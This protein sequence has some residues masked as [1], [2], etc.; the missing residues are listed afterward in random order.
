MRPGYQGARQFVS[1]AI[2]GGSG[3]RETPRLLAKWVAG[4]PFPCRARVSVVPAGETR[5]MRP[6]R[7]LLQILALSGDAAVAEQAPGEDGG[8]LAKTGFRREVRF[9]DGRCGHGIGVPNPR[10][11]HRRGVAPMDTYPE[12]RKSVH[13]P[14][15]TSSDDVR[16]RALGWN[17]SWIRFNSS[18][19]S[20]RPC[21]RRLRRG[22]QVGS[23]ST[24]AGAAAAES[25][26]RGWAS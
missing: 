5:R 24:Q 19:E 11:R 3:P 15:G 26:T 21:R 23:G 17:P 18:R 9:G 1:G 16:N 2:T 14:E 13:G 6:R 22:T 12:T 8:N 25:D 10:R 20:I 7:K 4:W